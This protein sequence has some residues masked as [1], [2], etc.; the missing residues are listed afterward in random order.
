MIDIK[1]LMLIASPITT[2]PRIINEAQ[3]LVEAGHQVSIIAW[4]RFKKYPHRVM[5]GKIEVIRVRIPLPQRYGLSVAPWHVFHLALWQWKAYREVLALHREH[6]IDAVHCHFLDTMPVGLQLKRELSIPL[7]YDA[8]D[9]YGYMMQASFP[10]WIAKIFERLEKHW[11][12]K[13]NSIIAVSEIMKVCLHNMTS[14]PITVVMNCK[15]LQ[16]TEYQIPNGKFTVLYIGTLHKA[17][18][19]QYLIDAVE[20]LRDVNCIIGGI[21]ETEY[22]KSIETACN[23]IPN[24]SF[25]GQ[26]PLDRVLPMTMASDVVFCMFDP[27]N[28]NNRIGTPN[29][30]FEAM[31]C[32]QPIICTKGIYSGNFVGVEGIGLAADYN[33]ESIKQAIIELRDNTKLR[34]SMGRNALSLAVAKYNWQSEQKK[35]VELYRRKQ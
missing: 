17:R 18:A 19:I 28:P 16:S 7:V 35:L 23:A 8:R 3:A 4:D 5:V 6:P 9:M 30:L 34:E 15:P 27:A 11:I 10:Y 12:A 33:K 1:I 21:G 13:A 32:G 22:V 24:I 25:V 14:R 20:D 2:D 31:V 29:K 26:V